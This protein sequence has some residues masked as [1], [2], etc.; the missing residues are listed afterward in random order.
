MTFRLKRSLFIIEQLESRLLFPVNI[1]PIPLENIIA[2]ENGMVELPVI[3]SDLVPNAVE[4]PDADSTDYQ[5]N[6]IV[7]VD[8]NVPDY[9]KLVDDLLAQHDEGRQIELFSLNITRDG[10]EQIS[11]SLSRHEDIDAVHIFSNGTENA[12]QLGSTWLSTKNIDTYS[13]SIEG[14]QNTLTGQADI[15]LYGCNL[16][17]GGDGQ[18]LVESLTFLIGAELAASTNGTGHVQLGADWDLEYSNGSIESQMG[19]SIDIQTCRSHVLATAANASAI[20]AEDTPVIIDVLANDT[21]S[22]TGNKHWY[23][24]TLKVKSGVGS[25]VF[26]DSISRQGSSMDKYKW[27]SI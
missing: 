23:T 9:Q 18:A 4:S 25:E 3:E 1:E 2:N 6:E 7:F 21:D 22:P 12:V 13:A 27:I 24:Y 16:A 19:L 8:A 10:I 5:R 11:E 26:I 15:L 20:T 17:A 14:W